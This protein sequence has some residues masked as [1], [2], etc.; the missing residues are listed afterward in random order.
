MNFYIKQKLFSWGDK[1]FIYDQNGN[2]R[3]RVEG[4]VFSLGKKLHL[5]DMLDHELVAIEQKLL[6]FLPKYFIKRGGEVV[7]EVVREFTFFKQNYTVKGPDWQVKGDWFDHSYEITDAA[8]RTVASVEKKWFTLG[9]AYELCLADG[10][11]EVIVLAVC[12]VIDACIEA[13]QNN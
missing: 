10:V 5:F 3:Y 6:S 11:D 4:K 12:L 13:S 9:D 7:A 2:E 1:F 8:G